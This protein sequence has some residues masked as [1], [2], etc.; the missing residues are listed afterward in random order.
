MKCE[1]PPNNTPIR[2]FLVVCALVWLSFKA[3]AMVVPAVLFLMAACEG[4]AFRKHLTWG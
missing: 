4:K 1:V 2:A 3:D